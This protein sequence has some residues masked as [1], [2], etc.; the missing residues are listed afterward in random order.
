MTAPVFATTEGSAQIFAKTEPG[1][2]ATSSNLITLKNP[3]ALAP[4]H[5]APPRLEVY[6][7]VAQAYRP[8]TYGELVPTGASTIV[9][10]DLKEGES[11]Q[12]EYGIR[13]KPLPYFNFDFGG[14]Y[15]TF[16]D[17]VGDIILP[18][19]FTS[20]GNVG[21]ARYIGFEVAGELDLPSLINGGAQSPWALLPC[22]AMLLFS[23]LS[24]PPD[25]TKAIRRLTRRAINSRPAHLSLQG[26]CEGR[27]HRHIGR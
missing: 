12:L 4:T 10:G 2:P 21:D 14:F 26:Q 11:L 15:F 18:N 9:N 22:P 19:G 25:L 7:T 23:T 13:G 24:S 27:P 16:D 20:T 6:G 1:R 8:R 17:Q 3:V 5:V